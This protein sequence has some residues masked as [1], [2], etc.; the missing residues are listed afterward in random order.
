[1]KF[2]AAA[3]NRAYDLRKMDRQI[4]KALIGPLG[5]YAVRCYCLL[6]L[7]LLPLV[8]GG[9]VAAP[10]VAAGAA[11]EAASSAVSTG[12]DVYR[13]GKLDT[14]VMASYDDSREAVRQAAANFRLKIVRDE[15][16]GKHSNIWNFRLADDLKETV[17][18]R[19][20]QR[21]GML[22]LIRVDVGWFGS[23]PT[24]QLILD[25]IRGHLPSTAMLIGH[26]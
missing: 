16:E 6:M 2:L 12:T 24:A 18:V 13:L 21:S 4:D 9:C 5:K 1:M 7:M 10:V 11:L 19:I 25:K 20:E 23:Q 14:A 26:T 22:C 15:Q 3:V 8:A 17:D